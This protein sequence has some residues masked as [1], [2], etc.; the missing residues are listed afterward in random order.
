MTRADQPSTPLRLTVVIPAYNEAE[1]IPPVVDETLRLLEA[2]LGA[3][4]YEIVLVDDGSTDGTGAIMERFASPAVRVLH[5]PQNRGFGA[6]LRTGYAAARGEFVTLISGDGEISVDQ[7][8][9]L[10]AEMGTA[11]LIISKRVRP[12][13]ASRTLFS[14]LFGWLTRLLTGFDAAEMSGIYV[15]RRDILQAMPLVSATGVVNFEVVIRASRRGCTIGSGWTTVRPRL[16]GAS[17]VTNLRTMWRIAVEL[18]KLRVV[19][20]TERPRPSQ[21]GPRVD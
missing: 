6:A 17:K 18:L 19:I 16:S 13:D 4:A 5:H 21:V 2:G 11:E 1:N 20:L 14:T 10:M 12:A 15:I 7:P 8:L 9:A 3:G